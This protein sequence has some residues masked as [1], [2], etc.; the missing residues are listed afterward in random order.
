MCAVTR[1]HNACNAMAS[2]GVSS[3]RMKTTTDPRG[4][5]SLATARTGWAEPAIGTTPSHG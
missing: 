4:A 1:S 5:R 2:V 3:Y